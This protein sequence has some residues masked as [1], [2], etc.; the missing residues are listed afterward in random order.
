MAKPSS[1]GATFAE[2]KAA[3][4]GMASFTDPTPKPGDAAENTT[5][6][7][8]AKMNANK[9][10]KT[11]DNESEGAENKA[12]TSGESKAPAKKA[13]AKKA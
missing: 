8:R 10:T 5:F 4:E 7:A 1:M 12:V 2:R 13:A 3:A 9:S 11:V 6:A